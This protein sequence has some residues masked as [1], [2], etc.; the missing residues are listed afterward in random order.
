MSDVNDLKA[1]LLVLKKENADLRDAARLMWQR[2]RWADETMG[3][4]VIDKR[5]ERRMRELGVEVIA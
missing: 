1:E 3:C 5:F 4:G 2:L